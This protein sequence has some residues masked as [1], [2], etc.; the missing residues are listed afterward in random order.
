MAPV[1][2]PPSFFNSFWSPD[3]RSGLEVLFKQLEQGCNDDDEI[4]AFIEVSRAR[5]PLRLS[6]LPIAAAN[7]RHNLTRRSHKPKVTKASLALSL[8]LHFHPLQLPRHFNIPS[9]PC[10][11]LHQLKEKRTVL[12]QM[13]SRRKL[14]GSDS[15]RRNMRIGCRLGERR[16]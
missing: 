15:G 9:C 10:A 8:P 13:T 2:L 6:A 16:R 11:A 1:T 14:R 7:R 3:Y 4:V 12:W 5:R